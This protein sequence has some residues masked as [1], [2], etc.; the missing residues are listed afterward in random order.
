MAQQD[1]HTASGGAS[2]H[3]LRDYL[4]DMSEQLSSLSLEAGSPSASALF[5]LARA[6][7]R[8]LTGD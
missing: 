2:P 7:L 4:V 5:V 6:E 1:T 3:D 8:K